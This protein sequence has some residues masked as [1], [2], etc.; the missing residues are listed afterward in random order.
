MAYGEVLREIKGLR[1]DCSCGP[2]NIPSKIIKLVA[3]HLAS[4]RTHI[5]NNCISHEVFPLAWKLARI[6]PVPKVDDPKSNSE[7][8]P[9]SILP[10]LSKIYEKLALR[11]IAGFLTKTAVLHPNISA[12]R[13]GHSTLYYYSYVGNAR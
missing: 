10:V 2:D 4:P 8:R 1:S 11:Q 12:Y 13:K 6:S 3:E 5:L 9:I 7:Y